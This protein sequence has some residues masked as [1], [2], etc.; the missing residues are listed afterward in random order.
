MALQTD[1]IYN[2]ERRYGKLPEWQTR[3]GI[4][5][6][7]AIRSNAA[8]MPTIPSDDESPELPRR[9][10]PTHAKRTEDFATTQPLSS[11]SESY[12]FVPNPDSEEDNPLF[13]PDPILF[14]VRKLTE[15]M[16]APQGRGQA[17]ADALRAIFHEPDRAQSF[18]M[19]IVEVRDNIGVKKFKF[20][21]DYAE[22]LAL[23]MHL[24]S[25]NLNDYLQT[26]RKS[27]TF[28]FGKS[29]HYDMEFSELVYRRWATRLVLE[30]F[31]CR[32]LARILLAKEA[33]ESFIYESKF[34]PGKGPPRIASP[35]FSASTT[36]AADVQGMLMSDLMGPSG[37]SP[38]AEDQCWS[39]QLQQQT[40]T[41][42][43]SIVVAAARKLG[44][45]V[46]LTGFMKEPSTSRM[47]PR[48]QPPAEELMHNI[49]SAFA[50]LELANPQPVQQTQLTQDLLSK[51]N[52]SQQQ[53][54]HCEAQDLRQLHTAPVREP[55]APSRAPSRA[56]SLPQ[57]SYYIGMEGYR[58]GNS[59]PPPKT[60][61]PIPYVTRPP[62]APA[63]LV[64]DSRTPQ[65]TLLVNQAAI[66]EPPDWVTQFTSYPQQG[67]ITSPAPPRP[68]N[69][70]LLSSAPPP[71]D[72]PDPNAK[73]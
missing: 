58:A 48:E 28:S 31:E 26:A 54:T 8:Y 10:F 46:G 12:T 43:S 36:F 4:G 19:P 37:G 1:S 7:E 51:W 18:P 41:S 6:A 57:E 72:P 15:V 32:L 13:T 62:S 16:K 38:Q 40:N 60:A 5:T 42:F 27:R 47:E 24:A 52:A 67:A 68:F 59:T 44:Q 21:P 2:Y 61:P 53:T 70:S 73:G 50:E 3:A 33:I 9:N 11:A 65:P 25:S 17:L 49:T 71:G 56:H 14:K 35:A 34:N 69:I 39:Q 23:A 30:S 20:D 55:R 29:S 64:R 45:N 66:R 63:Q 22:Q